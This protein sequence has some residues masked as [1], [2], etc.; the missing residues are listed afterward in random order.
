MYVTI[1]FKE[2]CKW[3]KS[4][5]EYTVKEAEKIIREQ[6]LNN[7][8]ITDIFTQRFNE[9]YYYLHRRYKIEGKIITKRR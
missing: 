7:E 8:N 4:K 2:N 6:L 5:E 3:V 1:Y 9:W